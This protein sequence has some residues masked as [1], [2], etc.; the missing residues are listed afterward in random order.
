MIEDSESNE[1]EYQPRGAQSM[2]W[3]HVNFE[4]PP[5]GWYGPVRTECAIKRHGIPLWTALHMGEFKDGEWI[6]DDG[7]GLANVYAWIELPECPDFRHRGSTSE[8]MILEGRDNE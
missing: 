2:K 6:G 3:K 1:N 8:S 7:E 4:T 5:N